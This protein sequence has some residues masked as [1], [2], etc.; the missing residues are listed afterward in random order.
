MAVAPVI[1]GPRN[2][3][4]LAS[5][6]TLAGTAWTAPAN[7]GASDNAYATAVLAAKTS[8]Q[9]LKA[10]NLGFT[11]P[12][13]ATVTGIKLEV[14][15]KATTSKLRDLQVRAV[16]D[17][18]IGTAERA[19]TANDWPTADTY[20]SYGG[21]GD[22]WGFTWTPADINATA[23]GFVLA[24]VNQHPTAARTA[25]VDHV[26]VTVY[27]TV[28]IPQTV[29]GAGERGR[30]LL[31]RG[32]VRIR[33]IKPTDDPT[34]G[35]IAPDV[36]ALGGDGGTGATGGP[37]GSAAVG[38]GTTKFGGGNG[39]NGATGTG[40]RGGGGGG[41][42]AG[43][44]ANG[45]NGGNTSSSA[46]GT[47][48]AA[49][50]GG[51]AGGTGGVSGGAAP[52]AGSAPGGGGGGGKSSDTTG[53]AGADGADGKVSLSPNVGSAQVY[54]AP[55]EQRFLVA[56]GVT[57]VI[58][59]CWGGG[60]GG[61]GGLA[62]TRGAGGGGGGAY[63][64]TTLTVE[65][66]DQLVVYVGGGGRAGGAAGGLGYEGEASL[67]Y[68]LQA[69]TAV[70]A[71]G[72]WWQPQDPEGVNGERGFQS[73]EYKVLL[74][75][76]GDFTLRFPN[77]AGED[78][79]PHRERFACITEPDYA[80]GEEW[81]EIYREDEL[82][83]VGTPTK[84]RLGSEV[85]LTGW[86]PLWLEKKQRETS[87]GW[88]VKAPRDVFEHYTRRWN[89]VLADD[90]TDTW[91]DFTYST[92]RQTSDDGLWEYH[93]AQGV[94]PGAIELR[95]QPAADPWAIW[96][97]YAA[98]M[99]SEE[100]LHIGKG[101]VNRNKA[102]RIE[103]TFEQKMAWSSTSWT[104]LGMWDDDSD[105]G[106]YITKKGDDTVNCWVDNVGSVEGSHGISP[107]KMGVGQGVHH[108]AIEGRGQW[109]WFFFDGA[110][111]AILPMP[112]EAWTAYPFCDMVASTGANPQSV[113]IHH[114]VVRQAEDFLLGT[115][116]GDYHLPMELPSGGLV[117]S[118]Y[119]EVMK[120]TAGTAAVTGDV[121]YELLAPNIE[122]YGRRQDAQINF[123]AVAP[124]TWTQVEGAGA[125]NGERV[126]VRWTGSILL[127]LATADARLRVNADDRVRVWVGKTRVG[128]EYIASWGETGLG[129]A[130][131]NGGSLRN[132]LNSTRRGWYPI[133]IE[134]H[135]GGGAAG[136]QLRYSTGTPAPAPTD[137]SALVSSDSLSPLG[138]YQNHVRFE[139]F[140]EAL[141]QVA[142]DFGIQFVPAPR[143]LES[144]EFPARLIPRAREGRDTEYELTR[145]D[146]VEP[147]AEGNAEDRAD[148]LGADAQGIADPE[149]QAQLS[150]EVFR[151]DAIERGRFVHQEW[152]NESDI[153]FREMLQRRLDS[154]LALRSSPWEEVGAKPTAPLRE[155]LDEFP[156][157]GKL[158]EFGWR[159]GDGIR[160]NMPHLRV[161]DTTPRQL[162]LTT[163]P[164]VPAG[165][166][167]PDIGFRQRP[168][169]AR[170][171]LAK[172]T[173]WAVAPQRN[174]QGQ[175][176]AVG[177]QMAQMPAASGMD[178]SSR[179]QLAFELE[180]VVQA[181]VVVIHK[182][183]TSAQN[184]AI[185][186]VNRVA[187]DRPGRYDV[188]PY[189]VPE[190]LT[191]GQ[192]MYAGVNGGTGTTQFILELLV[193]V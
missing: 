90:F 27:Y 104:T 138:V 172:L 67:A 164:F 4:T 44:A 24:A 151:F 15:R 3:G 45:N 163:W 126:S 166:Q 59:E 23:F 1:S 123:A 87:A 14:E 97:A 86:D 11:L 16:K 64:K 33:H 39:G 60:G 76:E 30:R 137:A 73:G 144:G 26:R 109:V 28:P 93:R 6:A 19:D 139:S 187:F 79:V 101:S 188:T 31:Q 167:A 107:A 182:T 83:Y 184:I 94:A 180:R 113:L 178:S 38:G 110:C 175:L 193:R 146:T 57:S 191:T 121:V 99:A 25:S 41:S 154:K 18:D 82:V 106:I 127:D 35:V 29:V 92:D 46:G 111:V 74:G 155:L 54:T 189:A 84:Y 22:L 179:V 118:Y 49:V 120:G 8:S 141:K 66:G 34:A 162:M 125:P 100:A 75:E 9:Y 170:A 147:V 88:H 176:V 142:E 149:S 116:P 69:G 192:R 10:S 114:F 171:A 95:A 135:G 130:G 40:A 117:G 42:S 37:G 71:I 47:G 133:I 158:A 96:P 134:F 105:R 68:V 62:A 168:R 181:T 136:I 183:D 161:E 152:E 56:P 32:R 150:A 78:G 21:D 51:G 52:V 2:P 186:G 122:P 148:V 131:V 61:A 169:N 160:V 70:E 81:V 128:E 185:N 102:W 165:L 43:T 65:P 63:A 53:A 129:M 13:D 17:G 36:M 173:R 145:A 190:N 159:P 153:T 50:T 55:G 143:Q 72:R 140:Y 108:L 124:N 89:F 103:L 91:P 7:A 112:A 156:L 85:V 119:A 177:G 5:D 77:V 48:G 20:K 157:T 58:V 174:Y 132:H 80:P 115:D 12:V 98:Q